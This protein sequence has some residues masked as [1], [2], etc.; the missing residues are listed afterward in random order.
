MFRGTHLVPAKA[1]CDKQ[2]GRQTDGQT[3]DGQGDPSMALWFAGATKLAK[4]LE[5]SKTRQ[6]MTWNGN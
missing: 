6:N 5:T 2:T 3:D 4:S 1:K